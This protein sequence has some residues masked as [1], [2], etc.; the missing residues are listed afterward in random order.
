MNSNSTQRFSDRLE[1]YVRYRPGYPDAVVSILAEQF[2]WSGPQTVADV[3][4]GTG[5]SSELFLRLGHSVIG[6][7]PNQPMREAGE[8]YL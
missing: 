5:F 1:N 4:S 2:S 3:G 8:M 7:E 6:I